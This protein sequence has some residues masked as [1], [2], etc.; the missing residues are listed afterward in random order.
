MVD[1]KKNIDRLCGIAKQ[2]GNQDLYR[3]SL[4]LRQRIN[5]PDS[6][7]VFLGESCSGKSTIINSLI[8]KGILPVSSVPSTGTITEVFVDENTE[9]ETFAVINQNATMELL[10]YQAFCELALRPDPNVQRLRA[11]LPSSE[12]EIAGVRIFD[13]PGYGS[14][15]EEHDEVLVDF[16]PNCDSVVYMVGYKTGIQ[17]IDHEFLRKL[18]ELT[19]PSIPIYL[20]V[21][22]CPAGVTASDHRVAEIYRAVTS[23][24]TD[25]DIPLFMIPSVPVQQGLFRTPALDC[26]RARIGKDLNSHERRHDLY[27][28]FLSYLND[29]AGLLRTELERQ[30]RNLEMD[31]QD[32]DFMRREMEELSAKFRHA[33]DG[34]VRPGFDRIRANLPKRVSLSRDNMEREICEEID[35]QSAASKDEMIA[36]TNTHLL[37]YYARK[38]AEEIQ[39]YL[40]V[41]LDAID[42]EVDNYLNTAVIKFERDIQLRFSSATLKAGAGVAK[43]VAGKFLNTGLLKYFAKFGGRGGA[44]AGMANAASHALKQVGDRFGHTFSLQTHNTVKHVMKK[45]GL[46]STKAL[47]AAVSGIL[48]IATIAFEYGTWKPTLISKVKK[49]LTAWQDQA[50]DLIQEDL[51][52][53]EVENIDNI[54]LVAKTYMDEFS[55]DEQPSGDIVAL[56]TL[57]V[58]L[59]EVEKEIAA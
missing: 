21:N 7:V 18:K 34:I 43:D 9:H 57:L 3:V 13:T 14:L 30:I 2:L 29:L 49:G 40:S 38:E 39:Y 35:R 28:A 10:D 23:L 50:I 22:R 54:S 56:R 53:L 31:A 46:T 19:R 25:Q 4:F 33:I 37:P 59:E 15:I 45:I 51:D 48:E 16:L 5:Q 55:V 8:G 58:T 32:A 36:Y 27:L 11:V 1:L 6:Y 42:Q 44:G 20:A 24:L 26:L 41:E 17:E 47:S 52:K 12:L